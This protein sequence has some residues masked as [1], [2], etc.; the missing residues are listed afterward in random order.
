M[1]ANKP[2]NK[3]Q[4]VWKIHHNITQRPLEWPFNFDFK[5]IFEFYIHVFLALFVYQG[6]TLIILTGVNR[7]LI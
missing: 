5:N 2:L 3:F 4:R 1:K 7:S 6:K